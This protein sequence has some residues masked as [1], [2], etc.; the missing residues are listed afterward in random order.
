MS[1]TPALPRDNIIDRLGGRDRFLPALAISLVFEAAL[2]IAF[3]H[4]SSLKGMVKATH[5]AIVKI[6]MLAPPKPKPIPMLP[7]PVPPP[8]QPVPKP[9][10]PLPPPPKPVAQPLPKPPPPKPIAKP[11]P[12][13]RPVHR[14]A[15]PKP[16]AKPVPHIEQPVQPPAPPAPAIS[17]AQQASATE[18]YAATLRT[19]VQE[20]TQ[21]PEAVAMMH[22]SGVTTLS[23][24]LA[25]SGQLM[26]VSILRSSGVPPIDRAALASVR[27]TQFPPFSGTMPKH[28]MMFSLRVRLRGG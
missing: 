17:A 19:K 20:N 7:K 26:A 22:L 28:P 12:I 10:P 27:A 18:L 13:P 6:T 11:K 15:H 14:I 2:V 9:P 16:Q 4:V 24:E 3:M 5:P 21:V 1:E 25:P 23:I 8:P